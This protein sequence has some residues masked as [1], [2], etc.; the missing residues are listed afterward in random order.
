LYGKDYTV[1]YNLLDDDIKQIQKTNKSD[2]LHFIT[3]SRLTSEKGWYRIIKMVKKFKDSGKK[4]TW[5]IYTSNNHSLYAE[6]I[7]NELSKYSEVKFHEPN[8]N[9]LP[10]VAEKDYLVQLSDTEAFCY[11]IYEALQ[12]GTPCITTN[13]SSAIEQIEDG[14]N[15]YI[16]NME[17]SNI[18]LKK[19]FNEIPNKY[20]FEEKSNEYD[21]INF[22]ES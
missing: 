10:I 22:L 15:G 18:D 1:I 6:L 8:L 16:L 2:T 3:C 17:L 20:K 11:S 19:I 13:F 9:I 14:K 4:F 5:D 7:I 12:V 21:W